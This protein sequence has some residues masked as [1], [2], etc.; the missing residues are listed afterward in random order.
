MKFF[1]EIYN[2]NLTDLLQK[3]QNIHI[4][5]KTDQTKLALQLPKNRKK[6][7]WQRNGSKSNFPGSR[8]AQNDGNL[9]RNLNLGLKT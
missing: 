4:F 5:N 9:I 7:I 6:L 2:M 1:L 3:L 8:I